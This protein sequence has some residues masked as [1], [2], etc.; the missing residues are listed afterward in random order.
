MVQPKPGDRIV[1][2]LP[3]V[4]KSYTVQAVFVDAYHGAARLLPEQTMDYTAYIVPLCILQPFLQHQETIEGTPEDI[5]RL[6]ERRTELRSS[7]LAKLTLDEREAL[8]L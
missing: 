4:K 5:E 2:D 8:G 6:Q 3:W 7:A 1:I